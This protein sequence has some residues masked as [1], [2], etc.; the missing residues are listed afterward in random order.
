MSTYRQKTRVDNSRSINQYQPVKDTASRTATTKDGA[1]WRVGWSRIAAWWSYYHSRCN[2]TLLSRYLASISASASTII[3]Q[4]ERTPRLQIPRM[5][6]LP[7]QMVHRPPSHRPHV[8]ILFLGGLE[9][10]L[11]AAGG[12]E[13]PGES[14][15]DGDGSEASDDDDDDD[16]GGGEVGHGVSGHN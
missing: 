9:I 16:G 8:Q 10:G 2:T 12:I 5:D 6:R 14:S 3:H 7:P 1:D 4:E 15:G 13:V 11:G